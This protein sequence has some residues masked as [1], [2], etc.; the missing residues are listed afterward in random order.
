MSE[1][2]KPCPFCSG[3]A[4]REEIDDGG[5]VIECSKCQCNTAIHYGRRENLES[6][7]NTRKPTDALVA[8]NAKLLLRIAELEKTK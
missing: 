4:N 1:P 6:A 3:T 5:G 2:L 7:W 8:E